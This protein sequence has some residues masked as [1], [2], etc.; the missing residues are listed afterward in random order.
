M[1]AADGIRVV[2]ADH[3]AQVVPVLRGEE[4][5][6]LVARPTAGE[7]EQAAGARPA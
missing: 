2:I 6:V 1:V 3:L 4:P 7:Q 5:A